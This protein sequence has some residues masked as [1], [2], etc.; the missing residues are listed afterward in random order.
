MIDIV[1]SLSDYPSPQEDIDTKP[2]P[3]YGVS[4]PQESQDYYALDHIHKT[5]GDVTD[6]YDYVN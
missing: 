3:V 4:G 2:I 1:S 5:S 6:T